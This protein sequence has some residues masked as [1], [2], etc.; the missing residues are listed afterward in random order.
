[1]KN[2]S[3]YQ[4]GLSV[5]PGNY[6]PLYK[7]EEIESELKHTTQTTFYP[8]QVKELNDAFK[9]EVAIPG[10]KKEDFLLQADENVLSLCMMHKEIE[11]CKGT[12][13]ILEHTNCKCYAQ[14][15]MLPDN[16]DTEFINAQYKAGVLCLLIPKAKAH[17]KNLH[18]RIVVY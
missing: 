7:K 18:T 5:Y 11:H 9:I 12:N 17:E 10:V 3:D 13:F 6:V 4:S 1:M 14:N 2:N 16:T 15:I 8:V